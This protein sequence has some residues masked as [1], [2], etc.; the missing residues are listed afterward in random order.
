LNSGNSSRQGTHH[1]AQKFT[2]RG[3]P[4]YVARSS[5]VPSIVVPVTAGM[6]SPV[7]ALPPEP[8]QAATTRDRARRMEAGDR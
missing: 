1:E 4:R 2:M 8:P 5:V 6:G 7:L 3:L